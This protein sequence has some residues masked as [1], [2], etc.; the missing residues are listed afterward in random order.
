MGDFTPLTYLNTGIKYCSECW[1]LTGIWNFNRLYRLT[2]WSD[3]QT[4]DIFGINLVDLPR[5]RFKIYNPN[6]F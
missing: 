6:A 5:K 4:V 1:K 2:G 3:Q